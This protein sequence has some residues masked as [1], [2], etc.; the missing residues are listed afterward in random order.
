MTKKKR[1]E[2]FFQK[3]FL[4]TLRC[5]IYTCGVYGSANM[6]AAGQIVTKMNKTGHCPSWF[7][8]PHPTPS[9]K[10]EPTEATGTLQTAL[11]PCFGDP[12]ESDVGDDSLD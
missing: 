8:R 6:G 1:N 5:V 12:Q 7:F 10:T 3:C 4:T 11:R 9:E 2:F